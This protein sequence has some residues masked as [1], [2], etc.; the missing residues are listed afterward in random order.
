MHVGRH[1]KLHLVISSGKYRKSNEKLEN[2][3]SNEPK[4]TRTEKHGRPFYIIEES[5]V[6]D[7]YSLPST[8]KCCMRGSSLLPTKTG[9]NRPCDARGT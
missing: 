9:V 2:K 7:I 1:Q 4:L 3:R 8:L 5:F 6:M